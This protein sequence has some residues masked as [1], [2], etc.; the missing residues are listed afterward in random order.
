MEIKA[1]KVKMT[2]VGGEAE[3]RGRKEARRKG[4]EKT[5]ERKEAG[6]TKDGR[7]MGNLGRREE[8]GK[9]RGGSKETGSREVL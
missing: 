8:G 7:R 9:I 6:S 3:G 2:K 4:K 1:E 5:R